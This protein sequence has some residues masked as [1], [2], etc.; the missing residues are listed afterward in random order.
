MVCRWLGF[1][2]RTPCDGIPLCRLGAV[3]KYSKVVSS[4]KV[5]SYVNQQTAEI[6]TFDITRQLTWMI[7]GSCRSGDL[8]AVVFIWM[9]I[10]LEP[11]G[12]GHNSG[13]CMKNNF[14]HG[15]RQYFC[16]M[17]TL[18]QLHQVSSTDLEWS[19]MVE[20]TV[21]KQ[22]GFKKR[23]IDLNNKHAFI[24]AVSWRNQFHGNMMTCVT[25]F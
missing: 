8:L 23:V 1:V 21:D 10:M 24:V 19:L 25:L 11:R 2:C 9:S 13:S 4:V 6:M 22:V 3:I 5:S 20:W 7:L 17:Q 15:R 12:S 14:D 16:A 18:L